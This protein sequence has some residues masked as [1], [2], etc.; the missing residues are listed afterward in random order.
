MRSLPV[1]FLIA[2]LACLGGC[3]AAATRESGRGAVTEA[4]SADAGSTG[5][6]QTPLEHDILERANRT[7][8][9]LD[10]GK[11]V[12]AARELD[13]LREAFPGSRL[14][15]MFETFLR[16]RLEKVRDRVEPAKPSFSDIA[17]AGEKLEQARDLIREGQL[18]KAREI[19]EQARALDPGNKEA[20][21][22]L[23]TVLK[24]IGLEFYS[25]G[26]ATHAVGVW[27]RALDIRPGDAELLRFLKRADSVNRKL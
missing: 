4:G 18:Q 17:A 20:G 11:L 8:D 5:E 23:F 16:G 9:Q 2:G 14:A 26:D 10:Q 27:R 12:E 6:S 21:D 25:K 15:V 24:T 19:L 22:A 3:H 1:K 13:G 7:L